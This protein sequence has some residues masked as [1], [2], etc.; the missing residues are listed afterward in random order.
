LN[1][2]VEATAPEPRERLLTRA[3]AAVWICSFGAFVA[4]GAQLPVLPRFAEGPLDAGAV[5]IGLA[6][7]A[8]SITALLFQPLAGRI[9][10]RTG[11]RRI[12]LAGTAL[13][14]AMIAA[15]TLA[16]G[17]ATLVALRLAVGVGE[18]CWFVAAATMVADLAPESRR[19]EAL[20]YFTLAA[21]GGLAIGPLVGDLVL[22][23]AGYDAVWL[24]AAGCAAGAFLL[25]LRLPET[26]Q[27][28]EEVASGRWVYRPALSAGLVLLAALMSF[29]GFNA[30][31]ALYA[32]ELGLERT[33]LVFATFAVVVIAV[34]SLGA[35]LPDAL[36]PRR[37]ATI[38]LVGLAAGMLLIAA[39]PSQ[40]G[41]FAGT[42]V[43]SFGQ[44]L[45]F[46]AL[47]AFVV[48]GAPAHER[49]AAVGT[50]S[51]FVDLAI[52]SGAVFLG[53]VVAVSGYRGAFLTAALVAAA[54]LLLLARLPARRTSRA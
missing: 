14:A 11:R 34:R 3:F 45:A 49:S 17:L 26:R 31:V 19:G 46:P 38:A 36:G 15:Y 10:D 9:A 32:L 12:L 54:G 5:G 28:H 40:V 13:A 23:L 30:F 48:A 2:P 16:D 8:S 24:T 33:G 21:Y 27:E 52:A 44:A 7:G 53:A 29:G 37:A 1:R 42:V 39:W 47:M 35:R 4:I 43:F 25:S 20:S 50:L 41:L 51:A 6:V 22:D 18:A